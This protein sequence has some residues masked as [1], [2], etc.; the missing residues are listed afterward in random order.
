MHTGFSASFAIAFG[1]D[2]EKRW[3]AHSGTMEAYSSGDDFPDL[4]CRYGRLYGPQIVLLVSLI[5]ITVYRREMS[6]NHCY[7]EHEESED[8]STAEGSTDWFEQQEETEEL[9][10]SAGLYYS[11]ASLLPILTSLLNIWN[12]KWRGPTME[13][14]LVASDQIASILHMHQKYRNL[15]PPSAI[16]IPQ[17]SCKTWPT[18]NPITALPQDALV[19]VLCF[20]HPKDIIKFACVDK[21][22]QYLLER[23][24]SSA[25]LWKNIWHR[26]YAWVVDSW[27]VGR[28]AR[29][30][31]GDIEPCHGK[32]FYFLFGLSYLNYVLAGH[33]TTDRC[34]IGL[35]GH[36]YD[37]TLFLT[38]HPG[39]P[40]TVM[41]FAGKESSTFFES[42]RHSMGARRLAQ[43][44]CVVVDR[45]RLD[46]ESCGLGATILTEGATAPLIV[47][48]PPIDVERFPEKIGT[49]QMV[50]DDFLRQQN[51]NH[52]IAS[53]RWSDA[54]I[55]S[56][57]NVYFDPFLRVWKAWYTD[58]NLEAVFTPPL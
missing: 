32:E 35:R 46:R 49:L 27:N 36:I 51:S 4:V 7:A 57:V 52:R 16:A 47:E 55:S 34:L 29:E 12:N 23:G 20:L 1:K 24:E 19:H 58:I 5:A 44:M 10:E 48:Q 2:S 28:V 42:I 40:E 3:V 30:R 14:L 6:C 41:A 26:D 54:S 21:S 15:S 37:L 56:D 38:S 17:S 18:A 11:G 53:A 33:N 13:E 25:A 9:L 8:K 22:C 50:L 45:S 39:S 43:S 31:S